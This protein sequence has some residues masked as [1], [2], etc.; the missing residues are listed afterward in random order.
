M[1]QG[2]SQTK[3]S[4]T[5]SGRGAVL[6]VVAA[7]VALGFGPLFVRMAD[8][9][10]VSAGFW[11]LSLAAPVLLAAAWWRD[12][13]PFRAARGYWWVLLFAGLAFAGD[14]ASWHIGILKTTLANSTLFGNCAVLIFPI[15]GFLTAR[16]WPTRPQAAALLLA[17]IGGGLLLGRSAELSPRYVV[18]DLFCVLAGVLYAVYFILMRGARERMAPLPALALSTLVSILP[19]LLLASAL[20]E[21]VWPGNWWPLLGVALLSQVVGQGLTI[22]ALGHLSPLVIGIALLVQPIVAGS[23]GWVIYGERLAPLDM[24]GALLVA[25]ALVLVRGGPREPDQLASAPQ[26]STET[27][28]ESR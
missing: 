4:R 24:L 28:H 14:L 20:G 25:V 2:A 26:G 19:M 8:V 21:H 17:A 11:R 23:L 27:A 6:A 16:M 7:N 1:H 12:G 5:Q 9:G 3:T 22:Y 15:Y 18:G 13:S 10:P